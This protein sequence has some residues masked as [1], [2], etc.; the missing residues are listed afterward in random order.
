MCAPLKKEGDTHMRPSDP[1]LRLLWDTGRAGRK[2]GDS[3]PLRA[4]APLRPQPPLRAPCWW[5]RV[6]HVCCV[7]A[8]PSTPGRGG[9]GTGGRVWAWPCSVFAPG[10]FSSSALPNGLVGREAGEPHRGPD[11][12]R[13]LFSSMTLH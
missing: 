2:S 4:V 13:H 12:A 6:T 8:P 7:L 10:P 3:D 1:D 5:P 9:A 11:V